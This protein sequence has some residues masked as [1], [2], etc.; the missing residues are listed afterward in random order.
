MA[1]KCFE[2]M[3][4]RLPVVVTKTLARGAASSMVV[5]SYPA[6]AAC[7][8]LIGSISVTITRAPYDFK[9]SAHYVGVRQIRVVMKIAMRTYTLAYITV[10]GNDSNLTSKH[11]ISST[12]DTIDERLSATIIVVEFTLCYRVVDVDGCDFQF[13]LPKHS[14]Q[15]MNAGSCLLRNTLDSSQKVWEFLVHHGG[16]VTTIVQNHVERLAIAEGPQTLFN[17]PEVFLFGLALPSKDRD[18]SGRNATMNLD[19]DIAVTC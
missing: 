16:K 12:L 19:T 13:V 6:I 9:D 4:S 11:D 2:V 17:T 8:A 7:K 3:M 1:R 10:P 14:V 5:T 18:T 15:V